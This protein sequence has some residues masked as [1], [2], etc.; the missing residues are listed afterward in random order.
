MGMTV[1]Y[2]TLV[3]G[4]I[5]SCLSRRP[6]GLRQSCLDYRS[7]VECRLA[8][9]IKAAAVSTTTKLQSVSRSARYGRGAQDSACLAGLWPGHNTLLLPEQHAEPDVCRRGQESGSR[10]STQNFVPEHSLG[11][12]VVMGLAAIYCPPIQSAFK[13]GTAF[14]FYPFPPV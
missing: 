8:D 4:Q 2:W 9:V 11:S 10:T 13:T 3:V 12:Q 6:D 5:A 1:Y 14:G 7:S